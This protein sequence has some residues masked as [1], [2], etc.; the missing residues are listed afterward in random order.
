MIN[1][2][3]KAI[4]QKFQDPENQPS[5]Y[6]QPKT[7]ETWLQHHGK[8]LTKSILLFFTLALITIISFAGR[9]LLG[10][11]FGKN[12]TKETNNNISKKTALMTQE[13]EYSSPTFLHHAID[14]AEGQSVTVTPAMLSMTDQEHFILDK[15]LTD[16]DN[17]V[18]HSVIKLPNDLLA[19][20]QDDGTISIWNTKINKLSQLLR[21][22]NAPVLA[23]TE[24]KYP[25]IASADQTGTVRLWDI[26]TGQCTNI[27]QDYHGRI[28][29]MGLLDNEV[30]A[31]GGDKNDICIWNTKTDHS[32]RLRLIGHNNTILAITKLN[33]DTPL[34]ASGSADNTIG[35]FNWQT[36][37]KFEP[38]SWH[39][40]DVTALLAGP[41]GMLI[42]GSLDKTI[43][44]GNIT[45]GIREQQLTGHHNTVTALVMLPAGG[46][47]LISGSD[48]KTI[49]LWDIDKQSGKW[50]ARKTF[51]G[52]KESITGVAALSDETFA[53]TSWD[54]FVFTWD[55]YCD[56]CTDFLYKSSSPITSLTTTT[57]VN[58]E[59]IISADKN[60]DLH[61]LDINSG[62]CIGSILQN[63]DDIISSVKTIKPNQ[64]ATASQSGQ[65]N[66][67]DFATKNITRTFAIP[68]FI[69][70]MKVLSPENLILA[71]KDRKIWVLNINN[72]TTQEFPAHTNNIFDLLRLSATNIASCSSDGTIRKLNILTGNAE[73]FTLPDGPILTI[74]NIGS[75]TIAYAGDKGIIGLLNTTSGDTY[76]RLYGHSTPI[77]TLA[78]LGNGR[79]V[80]GDTNGIILIHDLQHSGTITKQLNGHKGNLALVVLTDGRLAATGESGIVEIWRPDG[81]PD[82]ERLFVVTILENGQFELGGQFVTSFTQ[83]QINKGY[84]KFGHSGVPSP[85]T[86]KIAIKIGN[87]TYPFELFDFKFFNTTIVALISAGGGIVFMGGLVGLGCWITFCCRKHQKDNLD[88]KIA[89]ELDLIAQNG[90]I[91]K[92]SDL[93]LGQEL[94]HGATAFVFIAQWQ[95]IPV[96]VKVFNKSEQQNG[97]DGSSPPCITEIK[98]L[99]RLHHPDIVSFYGACQNLEQYNSKM[100]LVMELMPKGTLSKYLQSHPALPWGTRIK[101]AINITRGLFFLH[102]QKPPILHR[103]LKSDNVLLDERNHAKISDFGM[104]IGTR[105]YMAPE[106]LLAQFGRFFTQTPSLASP[107][108]AP[109]TPIAATTRIVT[110]TTASDIYSLG[111]L[112]WEIAALDYPY[113]SLTMGRAI[114]KTIT[115]GTRPEIPRATTPPQFAKLIEDCWKGHSS[116]RPTAEQVL[117]RLEQLSHLPSSSTSASPSA[118]QPFQPHP[119]ATP[120]RSPLHSALL[121]ASLSPPGQPDSSSSYEQTPL[122]TESLNSASYSS[123]PI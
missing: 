23:I 60:N 7:S 122:L 6:P 42:S 61:F 36:G 88:K 20:A 71:G 30:L 55:I 113:K 21:G 29:A 104:A 66:I 17:S 50:L 46:G 19:V 27:F 115:E 75:E 69:L 15:S 67:I 4:I 32:C 105:Q 40:A 13:E 64:I 37:E 111:I 44:I 95:R 74:T 1:Q 99:A 91:I 78:Y 18:G 56:S 89:T 81:T 117:D 38:L 9:R 41:D 118:H 54:K 59:L 108:T 33:L 62:S 58:N 10:R 45:T 107:S 106:L 98:K 116:E 119:R 49:K 76:Q 43:G 57:Y 123:I 77:R 109:P 87:T 84:L 92:S 90:F 110:H 86:G 102:S 35:I 68:D 24:I 48:D 85:P 63:S 12:N 73:T 97:S 65:I 11:L 93:V 94:G 120:T 52:H 34:L 83:E 121:T 5:Q 112:L 26:S 80:S 28:N 53:S 2:P 3:P 25:I 47:K 100:C 101:F 31:I 8:Q 103:D 114:M 72:G 51:Y 16:G 70:T 14:I 82:A 96:A 22:H 79:L 39:T